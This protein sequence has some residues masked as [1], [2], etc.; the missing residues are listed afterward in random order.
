MLNLDM[1]PSRCRPYQAAPSGCWVSDMLKSAKSE[2]T[3][4]LT[5]W[6]ADSMR[7]VGFESTK[8]A[9]SGL[10]I[11]T[12]RGRR[13]RES[14]T[15]IGSHL[16]SSGL[17]KRI[18]DKGIVGVRIR[19]APAERGVLDFESLHN[20]KGFARMSDIKPLPPLPLTR[21]VF[22]AAMGGASQLR[23]CELAEQTGCRQ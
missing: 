5:S 19:G 18:G 7:R 16:A 6:L 23:C 8:A 12:R 17:E 1:P 9:G 22:V 11:T 20:A 14:A 3:V 2:R 15:E 10:S 13:S 4:P 21:S